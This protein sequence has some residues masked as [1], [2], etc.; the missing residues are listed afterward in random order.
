MGR[1][2]V[3]VFSFMMKNWKSLIGVLGPILS[4]AVGWR[5]KGSRDKLKAERLDKSE[6]EKQLNLDVE[7]AKNETKDAASEF[8]SHFGDSG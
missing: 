4:V 5:L 2:I 7:D 8:T 1:L 3:A 6:L